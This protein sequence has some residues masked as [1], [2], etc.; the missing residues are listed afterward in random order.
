M[1]VA[2]GTVIGL[3]MGFA[4]EQLMNSKL[5]NAG[6]V[7]FV[8]YVIVVPT[9]LAAYVPAGK[10]ARIAPTRALQRRGSLNAPLR[11]VCG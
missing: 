6:G 11:R 4:V 7:D 8:A 3:V 9:K 5:F 10:A 1:L 2:T